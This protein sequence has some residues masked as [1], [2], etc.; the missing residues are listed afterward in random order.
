MIYDVFVFVDFLILS[1]VPGHVLWVW[2]GEFGVRRRFRVNKVWVRERGVRRFM[3][4]RL[5]DGKVYGLEILG[6][7]AVWVGEFGVRK[8]EVGG[9]WGAKSA[10]IH[11]KCVPNP[12]ESGRKRPQRDTHV[13]ISPRERLTPEGSALFDVI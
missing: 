9:F 5:C 12:S 2:V 6:L 4:W 10:R 3:G 13:K 1:T 11:R 8:C 7:E